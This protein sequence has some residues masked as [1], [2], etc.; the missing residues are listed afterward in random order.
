VFKCPLVVFVWSF[1][2]EA[3]GWKD[4]P[5]RSFNF[6]MASRGI[7]YELPDRS[8]LFYRSSVGSL[9][10]KKQNVYPKQSYLT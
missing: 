9:V 7:W 1:V 2:S 3:L 10:Y 4:Y 5:T 8:F 6:K